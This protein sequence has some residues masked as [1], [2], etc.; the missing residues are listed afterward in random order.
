MMIRD[1]EVDNITLI[2]TIQIR[3][4]EADTDHDCSLSPTPT[5]PIKVD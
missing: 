5:P 2:A 1:G 4:V 3:I